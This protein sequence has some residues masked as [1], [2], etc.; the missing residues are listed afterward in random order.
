MNLR[1]IDRLVAEKVMGFETEGFE[2]S[3]GTMQFVY[4]DTGAALITKNIPYYSSN[5]ADAWQVVE[6]LRSR[7]VYIDL[8][9]NDDLY[10]CELMEQD[11]ENES[12]YF[13][14]YTDA[15]TAPLAICLAAL[16]AVG[17]E[18]EVTE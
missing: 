18:V 7:Y 16:K 1:K 5:I 6:K 11:W 12:R 10:C 2:W 17:V 13:T 14:Y 9:N 8:T 4:K 15:E 3:K